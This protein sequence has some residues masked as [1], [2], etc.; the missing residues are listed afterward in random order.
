MVWFGAVGRERTPRRGRPA[1]ADVV[2]DPRTLRSVIAGV[3]GVIV[4]VGV[5]NI[6]ASPLLPA[7]HE[8]SVSFLGAAESLVQGHGLRVPFGHWSSPDSTQALSHFP[9]GPSLVI[10]APMLLGL[11]SQGAAL[12]VLALSAGLVVGLGY[13]MTSGL[14]GPVLGLV[15][16]I[17]V[18]ASEPL[19]RVHT[20]IWSEP[21]FLVL[22]VALLWTMVRWPGKA[23]VHGAVAALGVL[24]RYVG[25]G[26]VLAAMI[27]A[28]RRADGGPERRRRVLLAGLPGVVVFGLW[29]AV[30]RLRG[31]AVRSVDFHGDAVQTL[32]AIGFEF[33][34]WLAPG[35]A[36]RLGTVVAWLI[37]LI[38]CA[39]V[40]LAIR[41]SAARDEGGS[42][43]RSLLVAAS[44][45]S[46]CFVLTVLV[47][48]FFLD[49]LIPFD[50]RIFSPVVLL[51]AISVGVALTGPTSSA[52]NSPLVRRLTGPALLTLWAVLSLVQIR[53]LVA[54]VQR[55]GRFYTQLTW[56]RSPVVEWVNEE[57]GD[58]RIY[59][60]EP[61]LFWVLANRTG[62]QLPSRWEPG[63][64]EAFQ[65]VFRERPGAVIVTAPVRGM[66][67]RPDTLVRM[68][69]LVPVV[70]VPEGI[71]YLP[72]TAAEGLENR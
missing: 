45:V 1:G 69:D 32:G 49:P 51:F 72:R 17:P 15:P 38:G 40:T 8:D 30:V 41:R 63:A 62:W 12:L 28:W 59:S 64:A 57:G 35:L 2:S 65:E 20:A 22:T 31:E 3:L 14:L 37:I 48:R 9:P 33:R 58:W 11:P 53:P 67:L 21:P 70:T 6:N 7:P 56:L 42:E 36:G 24:L 71:V 47:S 19:I 39:V 66:D 23:G 46:G 68:L 13:W 5:L 10:A 60:N 26:A 52:P 16:L 18:V 29:T 27:W 50:T 34:R 61:Q 43:R 54:E 44:L 4:S 55:T 25:M